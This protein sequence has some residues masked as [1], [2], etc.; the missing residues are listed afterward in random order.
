MIQ[1]SLTKLRMMFSSIEFTEN[2]II[3]Q[4]G[5]VMSNHVDWIG[6]VQLVIEKRGNVV[7]TQTNSSERTANDSS[8]V[9]IWEQDKQVAGY[10]SLA[11][12]YFKIIV[13][14]LVLELLPRLRK[15]NTWTPSLM[16][17]S[18][19]TTFLHSSTKPNHFFR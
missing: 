8:N 3:N 12:R 2:E 10:M 19:K 6:C 16:R 14:Q 18:R 4:E 7:L 9:K 5:G 15:M 17:I 1:S 13:N 11:A